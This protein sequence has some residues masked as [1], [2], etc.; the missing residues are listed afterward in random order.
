LVNRPSERQA[1]QTRPGS[2]SNDRIG[3]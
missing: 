2:A 3:R 1:V